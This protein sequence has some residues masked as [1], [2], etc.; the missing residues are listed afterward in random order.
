MV[1]VVANGDLEAGEWIR[2]YLQRAQAIVAV[3]GGLAHLESIG[4]M[5]HYLIGDRDSLTAAQKT[6]VDA[7]DIEQIT[8]P[9]AKDE[10]DLELALLHVCAEFPGAEIVVVA[11]F[12]G[13]LDQMLANLLLL[14]H[15]RLQ[16]CNIKLVTPHQRAWLLTTAVS[17]TQIT[18]QKGDLV[19][20]LPLGGDVTVVHTE[21]LEWPLHYEIL[22]FGPAR[23]V[24]NRLTATTASVAITAGYLLV[25]HT[26]GAWGR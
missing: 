15:P 12:G 6:A 11:G 10:T 8:H 22:A 21:G 24:S 7:A 17:S 3:D 13:R 25:V 20:L 2:P 1:L 18:G 19:S 9:T 14:A 16:R 5:P 26:D 4:V 23:G